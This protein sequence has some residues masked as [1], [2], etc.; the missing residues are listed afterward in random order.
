VYSL[1]IVTGTYQRLASLQ[2]MVQSARAQIPPGIRYE[3]VLVGVEGD[4]P[5]AQ[6][7]MQQKDCTWIPQPGLLGAIRAFCDGA[8]AASGEYVLMGNDDITFGPDS[9]VRAMVHLETHP[10][11]GAVAFADNRPAPG[12]GAEMKVQTITARLPDGNPTS[13]PYPQVGLVRRWLGEA[14]GWWGVDDDIMGKGHTYGGDAYLGARIWEHGYSVDTLKDCYILDHIE[15]DDLREHNHEIEQRNPAVYY[16]RY[17]TPPMIAPAPTLTNPQREQMR[18]LYLPI[19]EPGNTAQRKNKRGLRESLRRIGLVYELDYLSVKFDL[20]K[21]VEMYQPHLLLTQLHSAQEITP[22]MMVKARAVKPDMVCVN[23]NGDA[24]IHGLTSEPVLEL[25]RHF[26]LQLVVNAHPLPI[27]EQRGIRAA[28]WQIGIE[29]PA[30]DLPAIEPRDLVFLGNCNTRQRRD[31]ETSLTAA[32]QASKLSLGMYGI[33]WKNPSGETLYDFAAGEAI[34]K[35]CKVAVG[36]QFWGDTHA[37]VSNRMFQALAAGAFFLQQESP[38]LEQYT[39]LRDG[40]H[41]VA[42]SDLDDLQRKVKTWMNSKKAAKRLEIA[43]AGQAFVREHFTF[44]AQVRKL[45][46]ELLPLIEEREYAAV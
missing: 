24:H 38:G 5:T 12:Y 33:G 10:T 16:K 30:T 27:Y 42:W 37:F 45:F 6:W 14:C 2:R 9:L 43:A 29:E 23:W 3:F 34:Y 39:G 31:L 41:Y 28:Y 15:A 32:A 20:P 19:L 17:A 7:A 44:D 35:R 18:I 11:A 21:L 46:F 13:V 36:D 40:V 26:D 25:L 22:A 1:S 8:K 4:L